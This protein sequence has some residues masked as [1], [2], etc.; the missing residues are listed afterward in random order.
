LNLNWCKL[1]SSLN[2]K[3]VV[4]GRS[5]KP[6]PISHVVTDLLEEIANSDSYAQY[7]FLYFEI[8]CAIS[9]TDRISSDRL[10]FIVLNTPR[11]SDWINERK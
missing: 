11:V 4:R 8:K 7:S 6:E 9:E 2:L 10:T 1:T 3:R 5:M